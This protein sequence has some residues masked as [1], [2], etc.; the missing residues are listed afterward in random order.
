MLIV[1]TTYQYKLKEYKPWIYETIV[2]IATIRNV[3]PLLDF[4]GRKESAVT[5]DEIY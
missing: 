4:E 5:P 3:E 2:I 1:L